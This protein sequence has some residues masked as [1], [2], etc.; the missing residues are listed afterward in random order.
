MRRIILL[1][2]SLLAIAFLMISSCASFDKPYEKLAPTLRIGVLAQ[3][4]RASQ[5]VEKV[6][7]SPQNQFLT[8]SHLVSTDSESLF[9]GLSSGTL[10]VVIGLPLSNVQKRHV[11]VVETYDRLLMHFLIWSKE[12]GTI[13]PL[14][15]G[16]PIQEIASIGF[17]SEGEGSDINRW[18]TSQHVNRYLFVGCGSVSSC[19]EALKN[20]RIGALYGKAETFGMK[21]NR[22]GTQNDR[23]EM[24]ILIN[25]RSLTS[26]EESILKAEIRQQTL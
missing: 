1:Y 8:P 14:S 26:E 12:Q 22:F 5:V 17:V 23:Y 24:S 10:D 2:K 7:A 13:I 19:T 11:N 3:D 21:F 18:I 15:K 4:E 16:Q 20:N 9:H 25:R 6:F